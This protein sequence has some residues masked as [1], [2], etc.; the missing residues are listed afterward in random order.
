MQNDV[1]KKW[2]VYPKIPPDV[3]DRL[4]EYPL[5]F[6]Q[7][8]FNRGILDGESAEYFLKA[9]K[10][11][12]SPESLLNIDI[13]V[14]LINQMILEKRRIIV[15]GDYDVDG[16]TST[17][18][19]VQFLEKYSA[20]VQMYI[21]NRFEEGYGFSMDAL[22][23][24]LELQ[25]DLIITVDCGVR[26]IREVDVAIKQG[27][28]MI[29]TDHHQPLDE[30]PP[31]D[32]VICPRQ[33]GDSY[34][35]K[36]LAGVGIAYKLAESFL[37]HYPL[38]GEDSSQWLD[39]VALGTVAD[40]APING[41]NRVMVKKGLD[42]M[43]ANP[44][45]GILAL[46]NVSRVRIEELNAQH[47]GF[48]L[49]PRLN[50]AGRLSSARKAFDL[51][52]ANDMKKADS[53]ALAL[54]EENQSRR[55]ITR[56][57]QKNMEENYDFSV[58]QWLILC[59]NESFN[60]G[61]IGLAASRLVESYYRPS[62]IGVEKE[63]V[64]R[65]SC[66]SIPELN[67]TAALDECMDLLIQHGGHA[68]AA[69]LTVK[70]E[71]MGALKDRL[72]SI[73][74]RELAET[75]LIPVLQAE[76]EVKLSDL[77]PSLLKYLNELEPTGVE[78]PS[79]LF[80]SRNVEIRQI[81]AIGR[82]K[83]HLKLILSDPRYHDDKQVRAPVIVDAIAFQFGYLAEICSSG[84]RIDI[85]YSYEINNFNGQQTIQLN[86]RDIQLIVNETIQKF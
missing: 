34:P 50:A 43:R 79:P 58:D 73:I 47:I 29:I 14:N 39:L 54:D 69:G 10:P 7:I 59:A 48:M 19:L 76:M 6:R 74:A 85:I 67:I 46:A 40:L 33:A 42:L 61:V 52:M 80:I 83:D 1:R 2:V 72:N 31:A 38:D 36:N 12:Y 16:V 62:V 86:V 4:S 82:N 66:R 30:L 71:N 13:A 78:N 37:S 23:E 44:R 68:M 18:L 17:A 75:E 60:E 41:E 35:N 55:M 24:V 21:P 77:H 3:N 70:K 26:S 84:D 64:V 11:L 51:L 32:V 81:N 53:L 15:F 22:K 49:G 9:E 25:P 27:V 45:P 20:N 63:D 56:E 5:I 28:K 57:I 65:A 8:L